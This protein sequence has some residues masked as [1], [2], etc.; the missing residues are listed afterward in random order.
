MVVKNA[1]AGSAVVTEP[2][3]NAIEV[4]ITLNAPLRVIVDGVA[5]AVIPLP[6]ILARAIPRADERAAL[7]PVWGDRA[8]RLA[9]SFRKGAG[10]VDGLGPRAKRTKMQARGSPWGVDPPPSGSP[11]TIGRTPVSAPGPW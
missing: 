2:D 10:A 8:A 3:L 4:R 1:D 9:A 7:P 11:G 6:A 5:A